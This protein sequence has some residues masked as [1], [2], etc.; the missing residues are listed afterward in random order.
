MGNSLRNI[1]KWMN[2]KKGIIGEMSA[3]NTANL[4]MSQNL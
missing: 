3:V 4:K 2:D 1:L